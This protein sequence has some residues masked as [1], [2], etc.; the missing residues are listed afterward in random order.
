MNHNGTLNDQLS[1]KS[2]HCVVWKKFTDVSEILTPPSGRRVDRG[3]KH[4]RNVGIRLHSPT[5]FRQNLKSQV[6]SYAESTI[7]FY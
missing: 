3:S 5:R 2:L 6:M 7:L 1:S 4:T